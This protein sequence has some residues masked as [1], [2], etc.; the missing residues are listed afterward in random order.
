MET[1]LDSL[2]HSPK[3][4]IYVRQLE[5]VLTEEQGRR[6]QFYDSIN[7]QQK[8]EFINGEIVMQS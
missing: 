6:Q 7:E 1:V 2:L 4:T 5:Q 8:V 3:L